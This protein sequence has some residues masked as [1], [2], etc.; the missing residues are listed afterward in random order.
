MEQHIAY[1]LH[2]AHRPSPIAQ[3]TS[4]SLRGCRPIRWTKQTRSKECI[5]FHFDVQ[6]RLK[7]YAVS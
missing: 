2:C 7:K 6:E 1:I 5:A 4:F 3:R